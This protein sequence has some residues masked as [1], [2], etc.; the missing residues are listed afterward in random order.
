MVLCR[1]SKK[2]DRV[3]S[4]DRA[5]DFPIWA[6]VQLDQISPAELLDKIERCGQVRLGE[7]VR[8]LANRITP[9]PAGEIKL[10]RI[11]PEDLGLTP[12]SNFN[13]V[14]QTAI[15]SGLGLI[16]EVVPLYAAMAAPEVESEISLE[17]GERIIFV[18]KSVVDAK[19]RW[20]FDLYHRP[21]KA[22]LAYELWELEIR[23]ANI[24]SQPEKSQDFF[25]DLFD[26]RVGPKESVVFAR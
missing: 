25:S 22:L 5:A 23:S 2:E 26:R 1:I 10:V 7:G 4:T 9:S 20:V 11:K 17:P 6:T 18:T 8:E 16:P 12:R 15:N 24:G 13:W 3:M 21:V 19:G 14:Y